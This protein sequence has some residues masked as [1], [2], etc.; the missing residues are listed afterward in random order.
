MPLVPP[1]LSLVPLA[2]SVLPGLVVEVPLA[3]FEAPV[4]PSAL[5]VDL[6]IFLPLDLVDLVDLVGAV[7]LSLVSAPLMPVP[8]ESLELPDWLES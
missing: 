6:P 5:S 1:A 7:V 3:S 8:I 4:A 2:E